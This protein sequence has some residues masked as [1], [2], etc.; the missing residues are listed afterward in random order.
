MSRGQQ[1]I[2]QPT[3]NQQMFQQM[4]NVGQVIGRQL[5]QGPESYATPP[6]QSAAPSSFVS[7]TSFGFNTGGLVGLREGGD[8]PQEESIE[9][10]VSFLKEKE[11]FKAKPYIPTKG[12]KP[13]IGYGHTENVKMTD[14]E[15]TEEQADL[16]LRSD[17]RKR[18]PKIKNKIKDFNSF[19][20]SLKTAMV[21][22][23]F[24]GSLSGSPE[25]IK[26][27]NAGE[28]EKASKEFLNNEEYRK[29]EE[30]KRLGIK[31]RMELV[32][33]E[34]KKLSVP[35]TKDMYDDKPFSSVYSGMPTVQKE[36]QMAKL[37]DTEKD[38][39]ILSILRNILSGEDKQYEVQAGDTLSAIAKQQGM[40][41]DELLEAN[42]NISDPNVISRGQEIT[43]PDQSSFL[44]RVRGA[45]GYAQGGDI[46]QYFEGQVVGN[47]DGM[48]DQILFEVEGNNPDKAL[49]SRDEYVIP[50]DVVAMLGN[51]SSNAGSEQLDNF[52]KGIRQDSFGTQKQQR[53]LN[54]QQ[55]L[56]GLV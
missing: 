31:P 42:K 26:L 55:G 7:G 43:V 13:T 17:I 9:P 30:R 41:L 33:N 1:F 49:L 35:T 56:R 24:R 25:T 34:L 29:A 11:K 38:A 3:G 54:A 19:P 14:K 12:D 28:Y 16:L 46:G 47:G 45:L 36:T 22:E 51:G 50:A 20:Q 27:I 32:S 6:G 18:L 48:S 8:I 52:I 15:I 4:Q 23:W 40:S 21:G 5:A 2:E 10:Y 53:Q 44:D 37:S 39:G